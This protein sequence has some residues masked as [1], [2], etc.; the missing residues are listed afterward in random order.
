MKKL[1]FALLTAGLAF[2]GYGQ[3][4]QWSHVPFTTPISKG[5]KIPHASGI[6]NGTPGQFS[7]TNAA[8]IS[9]TTN[10]PAGTLVTPTTPGSYVTNSSVTWLKTL[11]LPVLDTAYYSSLVY[12]S[13][14]LA[15]PP[16]WPITLTARINGTNAGLTSNWRLSFTPLCDGT[17]AATI[18]GGLAATSWIVEVPGNGTT[19]VQLCTNV[20]TW[21]FPSASALRLD[22]VYNADSADDGWIG[23]IELNYPAKFDRYPQ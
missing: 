10:T 3:Y 2:S 22:S 19:A 12:T 20:P 14:V 11:N 9:F 15:L 16:A 21:L 17:N 18:G 8:L 13:S 1:F 7:F 5:F 23:Q 6:T 4:A